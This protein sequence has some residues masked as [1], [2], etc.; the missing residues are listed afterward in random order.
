MGGSYEAINQAS[1]VTNLSETM[2]QGVWNMLQNPTTYAQP[3]QTFLSQIEPRLTSLVTDDR[4][5]QAQYD[6]AQQ[7]ADE[8]RKS[9]GQEWAGSIFSGPAQQ[10]IGRGVATPYMEAVMNIAG[11]QNQ[12]RGALLGQ[13]MAGITNLYGQGLGGLT[14]LG[15]PAYWQPDY[16]YKP[17]ALDYITALGG[18]A[19]S[20]AGAFA[21]IPGLGGG[22]GA[23]GAGAS[24]VG[25]NMGYGILGNPNEWGGAAAPWQNQPMTG[26]MDYWTFN[27]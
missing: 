14:Q 11:Q 21:G 23:A 8:I 17:G 18:T 2:T 12:L 22:A 19:A 15:M 4:F 20:L 26:T 5:S 10:A 9:L 16:A 13:G 27:R 1:D 7:K 6:V 24:M 25:Q 3:F